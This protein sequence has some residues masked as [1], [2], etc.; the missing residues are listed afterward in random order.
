MP[1]IKMT[2]FEEAQMITNKSYL[3]KNILFIDCKLP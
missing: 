2:M 1:Q 3:E